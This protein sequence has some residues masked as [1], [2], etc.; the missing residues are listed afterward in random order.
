MHKKLFLYT[1]LLAAIVAAGS[2]LRATDSGVG[3]IA[4]T[5]SAPVFQD[6]DSLSSSTTPSGVLPD[7]WYLTEL[8]TAAGAGGDGQYAVGTGSSATGGAYSF[9]LLSNPERALGSVGS[10]SALSVHYGAK[11]TNAGSGP[12]TAL[13]ITFDGEMWR[14]GNSIPPNGDRLTFAYSLDAA[15]LGVGT[16][17]P[18]PAL[19]FASLAASCLNVS[20][21]TAAGA[22]NGNTATCRMPIAATISGLA[23]NPGTSIWIR[24]TDGDNAGSDDGLAIDNV[25]IAATFSSDP[26]PPHT[27]A[28]AVSES[29]EP[30][31]IAHD[32]R[33]DSAGLQPALANVYGDVQPDAVGGA[34][35][36]GAAE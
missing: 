36:A 32:R 16:F 26:T 35:C 17:T 8:P 10:G 11:L 27:S 20:G 34:A 21:T 5:N 3:L 15:T 6:F 18:V 24:W 22:T 29:G 23:V 33:H 7:G 4:L 28:S 1:F 13:T 14:R 31:Q 12:I 25:S 2:S 30:G 9:G 19:N